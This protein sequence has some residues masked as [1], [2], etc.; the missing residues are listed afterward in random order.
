MHFLDLP[1]VSIDTSDDEEG[2]DDLMCLEET[3]RNVGIDHASD[4]VDENLES[5]LQHIALLALLNG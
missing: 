4:I 2:E 3:S 5:L 1:A